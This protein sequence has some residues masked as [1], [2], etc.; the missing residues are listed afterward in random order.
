MTP[1]CDPSQALFVV[2]EFM[3]HAYGDAL[4]AP[5]V[6]TAM[7]TWMKHLEV[8][9]RDWQLQEEILRTRN[10]AVGDVLWGLAPIPR[11]PIPWR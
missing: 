4:A 11:I 2:D 6:D 8:I 10:A 9:V 7:R 3:L 1:A 5:D